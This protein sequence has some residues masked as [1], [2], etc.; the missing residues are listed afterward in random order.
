LKVAK[1]L[2]IVLSEQPPSEDWAEEGIDG[3]V[4]PLPLAKV[5][6]DLS[7]P[8]PPPAVPNCKDGTRKGPRLAAKPLPG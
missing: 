8:L 3:V 6:V 7:V 4:C 2:V 5:G 1:C